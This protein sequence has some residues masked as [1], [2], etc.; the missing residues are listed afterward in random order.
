MQIHFFM[1]IQ[2]LFM[3]PYTNLGFW[4]QLNCQVMFQAINAAVK[5]ENIYYSEKNRFQ[6][7]RS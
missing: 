6:D 5:K 2:I 4:S 3:F 7:G 1:Q